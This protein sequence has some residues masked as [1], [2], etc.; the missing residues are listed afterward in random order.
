M[1]SFEMINNNTLSIRFSEAV[2]SELT[3]QTTSL[4]NNNFYATIQPTSL[5]NKILTGDVSSTYDYPGILS[6]DVSSTVP[7]IRGE[8]F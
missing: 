3:S 5:E 6:G 7:K 1:E 4:I 8:I 2:F